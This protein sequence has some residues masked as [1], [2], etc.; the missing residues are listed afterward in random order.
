MSDSGKLRED[1]RHCMVGAESQRTFEFQSAVEL[2]VTPQW[3]RESNEY[4]DL[5]IFEAAYRL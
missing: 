2:A 5:C 1:R 3:H 4:L